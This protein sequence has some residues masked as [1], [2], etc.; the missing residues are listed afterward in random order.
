MSFNNLEIFYF[1]WHG[2]QYFHYYWSSFCLFIYDLLLLLLLL[3]FT[4]ISFVYWIFQMLRYILSTLLFL[5]FA[6]FSFQNDCTDPNISNT[7]LRNDILEAYT[8]LSPFIMILGSFINCLAHDEDPSLYSFVGISVKYEIGGAVKY[9][10]L[11]YTCTGSAL[12]IDTTLSESPGTTISGADP[13]FLDSDYLREDCYSCNA[14]TP[15]NS[16][17]CEE[18]DESCQIPN[19]TIGFCFGP[20]PSECCRYLNNG[21]CVSECPGGLI[22]NINNTCICNRTCVNNGTL[23]NTCECSCTADY[24]GTTC[25]NQFLPCSSSPCINGTCRDGIG[26]MEYSCDCDIGFNGTNCDNNIND[27]V[28]NPCSPGNCTDGIEL[29]SCSCP[30]GYIPLGNT[31]QPNCTY[32]NECDSSPCMNGGNCSDLIGGYTCSCNAPYTGTNCTDC[33]INSCGNG[34][35]INCN[36]VC[37]SGHFGEFCE[38]S[39]NDCTPAS[40]QNS[41]ICIDGNM[42]HICDCSSTYYEGVN[43]ENLIDNCAPDP[44]VH[45]QCNNSVGN[46]SCI[47]DGNYSGRNCTNCEIICNN[48]GIVSSNC[49]CECSDTGYEGERCENDINECLTSPCS[50]NGTC[51]N[52]VGNYSCICDG[53][54][55]GRNCTNCEIICNNDGTVSGNCSCECSDTGYEGER[56]ENDINECLTSPCSNNGT[57][58]NNNGNYSCVCLMGFEGVNCGTDTNECNLFPCRNNATCVNTLGN[59]Y[60]NCLFGFDGNLCQN[61]VTNCSYIT[62]QNGGMCIQN[63]SAIYCDCPAY[64]TGDSCELTLCPSGQEL[65]GNICININECKRYTNVC[66]TFPADC[67]DNIPFY[68]C[69]CPDGYNTNETAYSSQISYCNS[70][71]C[72]PKL[73]VDRDECSLGTH[74]CHSTQV[75]V[76]SNGSYICKCPSG[77]QLNINVCIES[78]MNADCGMETDASGHVWPGVSRGSTVT[79]KCVNSYYSVTQRTCHVPCECSGNSS[80]W[81]VPELSDCSSVGLKVLMAELESLDTFQE[82]N[83][84]TFK[85]ILNAIQVF[86]TNNQVLAQD[87]N[88][89][90][91]LLQKIMRNIR[92]FNATFLE[93][94]LFIEMLNITNVLL[95]TTPDAWNEIGNTIEEVLILHDLILETTNLIA[96]YLYSNNSEFEF[97]FNS[98]NI[99]LQIIKFSNYTININNYI[100]FIPTPYYTLNISQIN[101]NMLNLQTTQ[102]PDNCQVVVRTLFLPT[103]HNLLYSNQITTSCGDTKTRSLFYPTPLFTFGIQSPLCY[104]NTDN[105]NSTLIYG[106]SSSELYYSISEVSYYLQEIRNYSQYGQSNSFAPTGCQGPTEELGYFHFTCDSIKDYFLALLLPTEIPFHVSPIGILLLLFFPLSTIL[107]LVSLVLLFIRYIVLVDGMTFVRMNVILT[108]ILS[109]I[110]FTIGLDRNESPI[111]CIVLRFLLYYMSITT[112]IWSLIDIVNVCLIT[113]FDSYRGVIN[114]TYLITGYLLPLAPIVISMSLSF[115]S[116]S[117]NSYFCVPSSEHSEYAIWYILT[118]LFVL[119]VVFVCLVVLVVVILAYKRRNIRV[120]LTSD[121]KLF[122]RIIL[123]SFLLPLLV[124]VFWIPTLFAYS[125]DKPYFIFQI[126]SLVTGTSI[127][128]FVLF[129]YVIASAEQF[130]PTKSGRKEEVTKAFTH[131]AMERITFNPLFKDSQTDVHSVTYTGETVISNYST[132]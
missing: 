88:N 131:T 9:F 72:S 74:Q 64:Y 108:L 86:A 28:S 112:T 122:I 34:T 81:G 30:F 18:C 87:I 36:C 100:Q 130:N 67:T 19:N 115:C 1:N 107:S 85:Q 53:Y 75:C 60:C 55:S 111:V 37:Y 59:F 21:T 124:F 82:L 32:L 96:K 14:T 25:K 89:L 73:C 57:C 26:P 2:S 84:V 68:T 128:M 24:F 39:I 45:G 62:C 10:R 120:E 58:Q 35:N 117:R 63:S 5:S 38:S 83:G 46:Y 99:Q 90:F 76:N 66:G 13:I 43:C 94:N 41:G 110:L 101:T 118:P 61:I 50:N 65:N 98:A 106:V 127:G 109:Q 27:C 103:F 22:P 116:Y 49:S 125:T 7:D 15:S 77:F 23:N 126:I 123:S 29:Y 33:A 52:S 69:G 132:L 11:V 80:Y 48:N 102:T 121:F 8:E 97:V 113:V 91:F 4:V 16:Y 78:V 17:L 51:N 93:R 6:I 20:S 79:L 129:I 119:L 42:T 47:C 31:S 3:L 71:H 95:A 70:T 12:T 104:I 114:L 105:L 40:C 54:Y 56:C 92:E 44:C